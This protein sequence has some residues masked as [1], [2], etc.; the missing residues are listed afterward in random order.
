MGV[1]AFYLQLS[2]HFSFIRCHSYIP[3]RGFTH[4]L[5]VLKIPS[6][7]CS[8]SEEKQVILI[9]FGNELKLLGKNSTS[10]K[11][12]ACK[13]RASIISEGLCLLVTGSPL[14]LYFKLISVCLL[15]ILLHK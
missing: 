15:W 8:F 5:F 10:Y 13:Y 14:K 3:Q 12:Q 4:F 7:F 2:P 9:Y 6:N 1:Y 11:T